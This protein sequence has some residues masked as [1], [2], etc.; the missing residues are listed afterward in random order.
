MSAPAKSEMGPFR[1]GSVPVSRALTSL[2]QRAGWDWS[3]EGWVWLPAV[4]PQV[5]HFASLGACRVGR[6]SGR[7]AELGR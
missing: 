1:P 5:R 4:W 7:P 6:A 3:G 2:V